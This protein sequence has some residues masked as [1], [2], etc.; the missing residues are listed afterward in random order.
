MAPSRKGANFA[1]VP[2]RSALVVCGVRPRN[3][4]N[5][6]SSAVRS[7]TVVMLPS[8][9]PM[10]IA[11][12]MIALFRSL[13][14]FSLGHNSGPYCIQHRPYR[15]QGQDTPCPPCPLCALP[16]SVIFCG[17]EET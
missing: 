5:L 11:K 1:E 12:T 15:V 8:V 7:M 4:V 3:I 16:V 2:D 6:A 14:V 9:F 13:W 17:G 10:G